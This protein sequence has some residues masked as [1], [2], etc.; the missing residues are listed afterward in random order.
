M[1]KKH[2]TFDSNGQVNLWFVWLILIWFNNLWLCTLF[3][4]GFVC[5]LLCF[6]TE[7]VC[8]PSAD[9]CSRSTPKVSLTPASWSQRFSFNLKTFLCNKFLFLIR[10]TSFSKLYILLFLP[11]IEGRFCVC[12]RAT[13]VISFSLISHCLIAVIWFF[14]HFSLLVPIKA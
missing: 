9:F 6:R 3:F 8:F 7:F 4:F 13:W 10:W 12:V 2:A 1:I 5:S 11:N 14:S